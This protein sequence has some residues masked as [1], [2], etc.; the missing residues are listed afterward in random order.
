MACRRYLCLGEEGPHSLP[1]DR[2]P[3]KLLR[4]DLHVLDT[5]RGR[6]RTSRTSQTSCM[7]AEIP[8]EPG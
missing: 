2:E 6:A 8:M 3:F 5:G 1:Q 7:L 4:D